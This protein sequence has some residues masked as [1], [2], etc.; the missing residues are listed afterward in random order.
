MHSHDFTTSANKK[1]RP[2]GMPESVQQGSRILGRT[3]RPA[4]LLRGPNDSLIPCESPLELAVGNLICIDPRAL[5]V[6]SQPF[7]ID[8]VTGDILHTHEERNKHRALRAHPEVKLREYTPDFRVGLAGG[9]SIVVEVKD[10]RYLRDEKYWQKVEQ[11]ASILQSNGHEFCVI[12]MAY[13]PMLPLVQ[14][15]ELLRYV[16]ENF[17]DPGIDLL[18]EELYKQFGDSIVPLQAICTSL[19]LSLRDAPILL[20]K[21]IVSADI[22]SER[23][24][25]AMPVQLAFGQLQHLQILNFKGNQSC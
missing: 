11:A 20:L 18:S 8:I 13:E 3:G 17:D 10:S 9:Q 25:A 19:G 7:T 2:K 22:A 14:N 16:G 1:R 5:E 23:I 24:S 4:T 6:I 15:G 21:G 12:D